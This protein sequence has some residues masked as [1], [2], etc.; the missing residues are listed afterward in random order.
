MTIG[1]LARRLRVSPRA[2]RHYETLGLL[3]PSHVDRHTGYRYYG[4]AELARGLRVEQL[5]AAG[6]TTMRSPGARAGAAGW[7]QTMPR[8]TA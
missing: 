2:L 6:A 7:P 5:K 4:P 3:R 1:E 8:S